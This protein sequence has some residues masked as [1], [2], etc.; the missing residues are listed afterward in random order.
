MTW[1]E[2]IDQVRLF[3]DRCRADGSVSWFRGQRDL[4][5][6]K[7]SLHRHVE[8]LLE[9]TNDPDLLK[10]R[11]E[12]L[13]QEYKTLYYRFRRDAWPLLAERERSDSALVFTMQ[14][15]GLPT[16]L[17]DW[18]E[19]FAC[20]VFFAQ[21]ERKPE[22]TAVIWALDPEACNRIA[23][24]KDGLLSLEEPGP[25]VDPRAWHP[26]SPPPEPLPSAAGSPIFA[27]ARMLAQRSTFVLMGDSFDNL[28]AQ[29]GGRLVAE[30]HLVKWPLPPDLFED[31]ETFLSTAGVTGYTYYPDLYGVALKHAA[32]VRRTVRDV[33]R[34]YP[35]FFEGARGPTKG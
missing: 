9:A 1:P 24:G 18:T 32:Y 2:I 19:S 8:K 4:W 5:P 3:D 7:S 33:R 22:D 31:A 23:L 26:V 20:A 15:H 6:L 28:D 30:G 25:Q 34:F 14:H 10:A 35:E 12:L 11:G 27:N 29:F 16:R 17:L 13:R 21:L